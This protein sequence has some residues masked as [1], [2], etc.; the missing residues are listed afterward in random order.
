MYVIDEPTVGLH[1]RDS[2]RLLAVLERL[3]N[4]GNTV[5][6]VEHDPTIIAGADYHV[7]LGPGAGE[8]GGRGHVRRTARAAI[9]APLSA[10]VRRDAREDIG[11][12][13]HRERAREQPQRRR[14]PTI[15]LGKLVAVTG[16]SGS[17]KSTLIRNCLYNRY[18]RDVRGV[19]GLETGKVD[20]LEGTDLIYDMEFVDQSPIGRSSRS[21]PG[22]VHQGLGRDPQAARRDHRREAERR[23]AP[24]CS[25]STPTAAA[26]RSAKARAP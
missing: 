26:A 15:P 2:E 4:A 11:R 8:Y 18:Q 10:E 7:E 23:H 17:G 16:V 6:V 22:H 14:R 19:A 21:N 9:A 5:I 13:P 24:A 25:R 20:A 3:R 12:D 1:A